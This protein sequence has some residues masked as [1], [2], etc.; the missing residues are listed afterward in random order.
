MINFFHVTVKIFAVG[1]P[2][3][4]ETHEGHHP[5]KEEKRKREK[6]QKQDEGAV[7][8]I[9]WSEGH[10]MRDFRWDQVRCPFYWN[11]P[12]RQSDVHMPLLVA[13]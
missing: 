8:L 4:W 1:L 6:R 7:R 2:L 10:E 5:P 3:K 12:K 13:F 9:L 11:A